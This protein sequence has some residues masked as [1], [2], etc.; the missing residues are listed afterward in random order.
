MLYLIVH[1]LEI[2][3]ALIGTTLVTVIILYFT[4]YKTL[5]PPSE[6]PSE[7]EQNIE[8]QRDELGTG[9]RAAEAA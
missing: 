2:A 7:E 6:P 1:R 5:P 4:W 3:F 8:E 9:V